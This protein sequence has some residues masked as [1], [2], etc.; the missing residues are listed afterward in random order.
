MAGKI[1]AAEAGLAW[2]PEPPALRIQTVNERL[3]PL[4]VEAAGLPNVPLFRSWFRRGEP[5]TLKA[6]ATRLEAR[7]QEVIEGAFLALEK[8][9]G[10]DLIPMHGPEK[11]GRLGALVFGDGERLAGGGL[12]P[13]AL[14]R[15]QR[16]RSRALPPLLSAQRYQLQTTVAE[17]A[18]WR[19]LLEEAAKLPEGA[20][21]P[22]GLLARLQ[23]QRIGHEA[24]SA[25]AFGLKPAELLGGYCAV[26]VDLAHREKAAYAELV[27]HARSRGLWSVEAAQVHGGTL[28]LLG[29]LAAERRAIARLEAHWGP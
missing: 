26:L 25:L 5:R 1:R 2:L 4:P 6:A 8:Q 10:R 28:K 22:Q 12:G 18:A 15:V 17:L 24:A 3:A 14:E 19:P 20:P 16:L 29:Q 9:L 11:L 23:R 7:R 27:T 13:D 21:I